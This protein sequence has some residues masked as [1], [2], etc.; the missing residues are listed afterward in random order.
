[1]KK[2]SF[3]ICCKQSTNLKHL[4]F[5]SLLSERRPYEKAKTF[6]DKRQE[7]TVW[8]KN[9]PQIAADFDSIVSPIPSETATTSSR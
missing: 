9:L 2:K 3:L 1:M 6:P 7:A 5:L 8:P 4:P